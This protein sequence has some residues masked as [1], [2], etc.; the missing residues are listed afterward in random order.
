MPQSLTTQPAAGDEVASTKQSGERLYAA[1]RQAVYRR[2]DR[3]FAILMAAQWVFGI[4]AAIFISPR[5]WVGSQSNIHPHVWAAIFLGGAISFFPIFLALK[6]PGRASTR[7]VI[8]VAQMLWSALLIHL[9]GGRIETHFH[10]F[11]SL[12]FLAFYRDWRVLIPATVV[13]ALDHLLRGLFFPQSVYGVIDGVTWRWLEHAAWV[14]FEDVFLIASCRRGDAEMREIAQRAADLGH[15]KETAEAA[16]KAKS[17]FL[18]NMSHE[19]RTPMNGIIGLTDLMLR[20]GGLDGQPLRHAQLIKSSADT[21]LSLI[22][23]VLDFSKI[24]AGKMELSNIEFDLRLAVEELVVMLAPRATSKG[25]EF[26][27]NV[28]ANVPQ[29]V[30]GDPDRLRQILTNLISNAIKFTDRGEVL[31]DVA[32]DAGAP[33]GGLLKFSV[34]DTGPGIPP[35]RTD[36][37]FKSFSQVDASTTRKYGGTGLGLAIARQLTELMGGQ[38][39]VESALNRGSTFWFTAR[40][41]P[42]ANQEPLPA[43]TSASLRGTRVLVA[44]DHAAFRDI[45]RD[46]LAGW[47]FE[48][49]LAATGEEA[50]LRLVTG[51]EQ[52]RPYRVAIVDLVMPGMSGKSVAAA[53]RADT[54]LARTSLV[55]VTSMD[56]S[57]D[58][59]AMRS[60]GFVTCLTKP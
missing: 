11:G 27:C 22:N 21:L 3:V 30:Q 48:V 26:A 23:N 31:V 34:R 56:N 37:L 41:Q 45:L 9:T 25:L 18:A 17:E 51:R 14:I 8:A 53:V 7:Y 10:V 32:Q 20:R 40:L 36:R 44:D 59:E 1:D 29:R 33:G 13:V 55:M 54:R 6:C 39:G 4:I 60:A 5:T 42:A 15:A 57:F 50:M 19:I 2:T 24:E 49:D 58:Q 28:H 35:E 16:T 52:G 12:A 43:P 47:G 46:H 38:I